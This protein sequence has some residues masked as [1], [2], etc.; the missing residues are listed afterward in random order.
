VWLIGLL[1]TSILVFQFFGG[2]AALDINMHDTYING[3]P[4]SSTTAIFFYFINIA[5]C[6]Y[7][8]RCLYYEFKVILTDAILLIV[9]GV[10]LY[11]LGGVLFI[12]FPPVIEKTSSEPVKGLFYGSCYSHVYILASQLMKIFLMLILSFTGFMIGK[13]WRKKIVQ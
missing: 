9:S 6:V 8:I 2:N 10:L 4:L 13:N 5:F 3:Q 12:F 1:I 7:F 11:S